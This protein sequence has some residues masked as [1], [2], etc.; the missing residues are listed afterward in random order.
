V[1]VVCPENSDPGSGFADRSAAGAINRSAASRNERAF[2][3]NALNH[4]PRFCLNRKGVTV[5]FFL[6]FRAFPEGL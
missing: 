3:E 5:F 2:E 1:A 4:S 6:Q